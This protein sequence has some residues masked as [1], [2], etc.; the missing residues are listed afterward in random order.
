MHTTVKM[1]CMLPHAGRSY[2]LTM[3]P[4]KPAMHPP[5]MLSL[6]ASA[7]GMSLSVYLPVMVLLRDSQLLHI[8]ISGKDRM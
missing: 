4:C 3:G 7:V 2:K 8:S 5:S 1:A 6:T